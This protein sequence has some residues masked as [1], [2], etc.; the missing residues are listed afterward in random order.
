MLGRQGLEPVLVED[1]LEELGGL[2]V[3]AHVIVLR[4]V[5]GTELA[6]GGRVV[7]LERLDH[8]ALESRHD[9]AARQLG[10]ASAPC[11]A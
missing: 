3:R 4:N 6:V 7:E 2:M 5:L 9:L 11:P 10:D 1:D 8:A